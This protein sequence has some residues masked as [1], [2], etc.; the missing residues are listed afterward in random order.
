MNIDLEDTPEAGER[1][2]KK[3]HCGLPL[4]SQA[5]G[6]QLSSLKIQAQ[7]VCTKTSPRP[8]IFFRLVLE[9]GIE[10]APG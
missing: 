9:T 5:K 1:K 4:F 6:K 8:Q 3:K 10:R 7:N 2:K